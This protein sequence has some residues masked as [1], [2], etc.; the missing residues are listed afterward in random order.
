MLAGFVFLR[1]SLG[2]LARLDRR[3]KFLCGHRLD[4]VT[5]VAGCPDGCLT[6]SWADLTDVCTCAGSSWLVL[7]FLKGVKVVGG[8]DSKEEESC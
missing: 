2:L 3:V 5:V 7:L 1:G 4:L 8:P 6:S